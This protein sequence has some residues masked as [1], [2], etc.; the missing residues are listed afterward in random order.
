[1][2]DYVAKLRKQKFA[3][4]DT[5]RPGCARSEDSRHIPAE[6][7]R[8]VWQ[9]DGGQC[10][11]TSDTGHRC[12]ERSGLEYDHIVPYALGGEATAGN[13]RLL[14]PAHNQLEAERTYGIEFMKHKR[15]RPREPLASPGFGA[16]TVIP[17]L[18]PG[19]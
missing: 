2:A 4:T 9:R 1:M 8:A 6:V 15:E 17:P 3:A 12:E 7:K 16:A 5:P 11:Y 14:C 19:T 10:T 18:P 13:I